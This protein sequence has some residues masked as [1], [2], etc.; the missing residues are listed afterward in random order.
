[1]SGRIL[2][3]LFLLA[4]ATDARA[5]ALVLDGEILVMEG[6]ATTVTGEGGGYS[7]Q[8][9]NI[10]AIVNQFYGQYNDEFD[11]ISIWTSFPDLANGGAYYTSAVSS[12]LGNL[13]GFINMN[14]V[15]FWT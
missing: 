11:M 7:I 3:C 10:D 15:G 1:M 6:D 9:N 2:A 14:Q 13:K 5:Q 12:P 8:G 4:A